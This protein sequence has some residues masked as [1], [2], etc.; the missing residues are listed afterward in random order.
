MET[1]QEKQGSEHSTSYTKIRESSKKQ[2]SIIRDFEIGNVMSCHYEIES[3]H[4]ID[5]Q[6]HSTRKHSLEISIIQ[7]E[8]DIRLQKKNGCHKIGRYTHLSLPV[9]LSVNPQSGGKV[10]S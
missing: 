7:N 8:I 5:V 3:N 6:S 1:K 2:S 9:G 4:G 10:K